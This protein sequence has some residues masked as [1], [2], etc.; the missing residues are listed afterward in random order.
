MTSWTL[1]ALVLLTASAASADPASG[2]RVVVV[3]VAAVNLDAQR[4][5]ALS[6]DLAEGLSAELLVDAIGGLDVRRTL[7]ADLPAD[8]ATQPT[9]AAEVAKATGAQQILFVAM[10]D[11]GGTGSLQVDSTWVEPSSGKSV[12]RP[13]VSLT[14]TIDA[15]AKA[16]FREA[17][18]KFL[19]DA[20]VR[21]KP[22]LGSAVSL[23][24]RLVDG[25]PRHI[26]MPSVITGGVAVIGLGVGIGFGLTARN[27]YNA[28]ENNKNSC[29]DSS[30][31]S[32]RHADLA[33]DLGWVTAI[34]AA[35]ATGV[36]FVTS[37]E[38]PHVIA[39]PAESGAGGSVF[40]VGRF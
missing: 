36:L 20:T 15:D 32:I 24:G 29:S 7:R 35:I 4:V 19:P 38:A 28:C 10:V 9:C 27:K 31:D 2:P 34:G 22:K 25:E 26:T 39:A 13:S 8:C 30:K 33:A 17:A 40:Y 18:T 16:R 5:D 12:N 11:A 37:A 23:D 1:G 14:S 21:P 6:A 3:P